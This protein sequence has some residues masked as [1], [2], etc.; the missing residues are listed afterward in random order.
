MYSCI[1]GHDLHA[2]SETDEGWFFSFLREGGF[3]SEVLVQELA[4]LFKGV[5]QQSLYCTWMI[6]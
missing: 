6:G 5:L 1:K 2:G 3:V 4:F